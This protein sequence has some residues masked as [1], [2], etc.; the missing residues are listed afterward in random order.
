MIT[1]VLERK[2]S[3]ATATCL[4]YKRRGPM[5]AREGSCRLAQFEAHTSSTKVQR[6]QA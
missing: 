6:Q 5:Y 1:R 4:P 2:C 3:A